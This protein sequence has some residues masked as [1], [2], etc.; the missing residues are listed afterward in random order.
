MIAGIDLAPSGGPGNV[1]ITVQKK[2]FHSGLHVKATGDALIVAPPLISTE[3]NI[4]EI[5][6][7]LK[8]VLQSSS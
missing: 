5:S 3:A 2:L 4:D 7:K 6:D 1:G 8:K